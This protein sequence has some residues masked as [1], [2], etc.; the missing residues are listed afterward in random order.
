MSGGHRGSGR[1]ALRL[2][3]SRLP[4]QLVV[5]VRL[6]APLRPVDPPVQRR[7]G[8][9]EPA[10]QATAAES[11]SGGLLRRV[12]SLNRLVGVRALGGLGDLGRRVLRR[13]V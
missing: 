2:L 7:T 6:P 8:A 4:V 5:A 9:L 1:S 13:L 12:G 3:R 10:Q 11:L